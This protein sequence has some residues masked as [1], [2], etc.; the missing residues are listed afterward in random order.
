MKF[1]RIFLIILLVLMVPLFSIG[2]SI[3]DKEENGVPK[4]AFVSCRKGE[5]S[6]GDIYT[7]DIN[8][9]NEVR[10]TRKS[11]TNLDPSFSPDG[12]KITFTS[13]RDGNEEIYIMDVTGKHQRR[14]TRYP[15]ADHSPSFSPDGK[16]IVYVS[17]RPT[18]GTNTDWNSE[19]CVMDT[20]GRNQRR[21]TDHS[22][23]DGHPA[24]SPDGQ[25]IVF[26][27]DRDGGCE[28]YV[29]DADGKNIKRLTNNKFTDKD[30]SWSPDGK[31]I[32]FRSRRKG[33][34]GFRIYIM[35]ANGENQVRLTENSIA[36]NYPSFSPDKRYIVFSRVEKDK[37][38]GIVAE[39]IYIMEASGK[40]VRRLTGSRGIISTDS[41]PSWQPTP[42]H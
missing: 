36:D 7:I 11:G 26:E 41:N 30:P 23:R 22:A 24:F 29:M 27:S 15:Y 38:K 35:D 8:G 18:S 5:K 12:K 17:M 34:E 21:L 33:D 1:T 42:N 3:G 19:I 6:L 25:Q 32:V 2:W 16:K 28:I 4:I 13:S 20:D 40:N 37:E 39:K 9:E 10:L 14:L 31:N